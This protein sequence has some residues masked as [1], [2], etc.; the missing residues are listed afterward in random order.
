ML[1]V[2][3]S[4]KPTASPLGEGMLLNKFKRYSLADSV[5]LLKALLVAQ[6]QYFEEFSVD[7]INI[8]STASLA[9]KVFRQ[10]FFPSHIS[11]IPIL[12]GSVDAFVRQAYLGGATDVYKRYAE[13]VHYYDVN[14]LYPYAQCKP[15]PLKCTRWIKQLNS[16]DNFFGFVEV[17]VIAPSIPK[18]MLPA[19]RAG[20]TIF[21]VGTWKGIYFSE[22]L[23]AVAKLGY[24]FKLGQAYEF[25]SEV[26]FKDY[27][28]YFYNIKKVTTGPKRFI[29][30]MMLNNLYGIFGRSLVGLKPLIIEQQDVAPFITLMRSKAL[31]NINDKYAMIL[32][33]ESTNTDNL[34][35]LDS[36]YFLESS[37]SMKIPVKANV[38]IAAAVTAY[39][40]IHMMDLKLN[41]DVCYSDTDSIFTT[42]P[43]G[44]WQPDHL[45][46]PGL[47]QLKDELAP[48]PYGIGER[49]NYW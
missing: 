21:P 35:R 9:M 1:T 23:K 33:D 40:R 28:D 26:L 19:R 37:S 24:Q 14:S 22:E 11:Q 20:R 31:T 25:S 5:S 16:L 12:K 7:I 29:A 41:Y 15:M 17:E 38:A 30:K 49:S 45:I 42:H 6:D 13:N 48:H 47:G 4:G 18:P 36:N 44:P 3:R 34:L 46:G 27:V 8:Y 43:L 32:T 10:R 39:A 2:R